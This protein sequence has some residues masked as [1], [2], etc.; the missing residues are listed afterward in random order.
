[1]KIYFN[2]VDR[3]EA[4][5]YGGDFFEFGNSLF[6]FCLHTTYENEFIIEDSVG[7]CMPFSME[8][9]APL[10]HALSVIRPSVEVIVE[11]NQAATH[12]EDHHD[13]CV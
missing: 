8:S 11:G 2:K 7:R 10:M 12:L 13:V 1:M 6:D 5:A 4:E 9:L 3:E